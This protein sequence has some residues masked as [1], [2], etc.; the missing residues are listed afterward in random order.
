[1]PLSE[2]Y[3]GKGKSIMARMRKRYGLKKGRQVFY[4][5]ANK[6]KMKPKRAVD[7]M[8]EYL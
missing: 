4:A 6:R 2:Y 3:G 8:G 1:M 7:I 5:A